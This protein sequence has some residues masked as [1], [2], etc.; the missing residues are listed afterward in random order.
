MSN[1]NFGITRGAPKYKKKLTHGFF[2]SSRTSGVTENQVKTEKLKKKK[3]KKHRFLVLAK[4]SQRS[5]IYRLYMYIHFVL[6]LSKKCSSVFFFFL[7]A[8]PSGLLAV[9]FVVA[10]P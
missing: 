2:L 5:D 10:S 4:K 3:K 7:C 1:T 8:L 9:K 6:T